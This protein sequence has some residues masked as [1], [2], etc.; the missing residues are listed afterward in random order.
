MILA[1]PG[2]IKSIFGPYLS[3]GSPKDS[4]TVQVGL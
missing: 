1:F 3:D 4:R 2:H